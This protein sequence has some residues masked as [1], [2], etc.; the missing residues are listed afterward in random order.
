MFEYMNR[1]IKQFFQPQ[2]TEKDI[3]DIKSLKNC[4]RT[5]KS[6]TPMNL[7]IETTKESTVKKGKNDF[8]QMMK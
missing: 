6:I 4:K 1:K 8:L 3:K 2:M 7:Y 5:Q